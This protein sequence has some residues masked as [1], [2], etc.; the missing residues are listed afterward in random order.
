MAERKKRVRRRGLW[1]DWTPE[2]DRV[3]DRYACEMTTKCRFFQRLL[4]GSLADLHEYYRLHPDRVPEGGPRTRE[5]IR[6]R[7]YH[8]ARALGRSNVAARWVRAERRLSEKWTRKLLSAKG[9]L[10][11]MC[12]RDCARMLLVELYEKGFDRSLRSCCIEIWK[13]RQRMTGHPWVKPPT[14]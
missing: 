6:T 1:P 13:Q 14:F 8:R 10:D 5:A 3:V 9:P 4:E 11:R 12:L 2:E 7:L